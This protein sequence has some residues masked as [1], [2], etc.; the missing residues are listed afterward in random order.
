MGEAA[1][2]TVEDKF[3]WKKIAQIYLRIYKKAYLN[4]KNGK[5]NKKKSKEKKQRKYPKILKIF[6]LGKK[7]T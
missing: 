1:R 4:G 3:V 6:K 5:N 7:K 2:K